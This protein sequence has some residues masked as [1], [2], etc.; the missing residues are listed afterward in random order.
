MLTS[1]DT[2][3]ISVTR[4]C[5]SVVYLDSKTD[6]RKSKPLTAYRAI[7]TH[8]VIKMCMC[9]DRRRNR[10]HALWQSYAAVNWTSEFLM[11]PYIHVIGFS[12]IILDP[13]SCMQVFF[14]TS[15]VSPPVPER[16]NSVVFPVI[17]LLK[18]LICYVT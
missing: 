8:Q 7:H 16:V 15:N 1:D 5:L 17:R 3:E 18:H 4:T 10:R 6:H 12:R 9:L 2:S 11:M 14:V 13:V